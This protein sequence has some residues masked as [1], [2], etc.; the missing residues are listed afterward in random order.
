MTV[1][2]INTGSNGVVAANK[3]VNLALSNPTDAALGVQPISH[4]TIINVNSSVGFLTPAYEINKGTPNGAAVIT[5]VRG[6]GAIGPASV[7]FT[8]TANGTAVPG[9]DYT[10]IMNYT[11]FFA[12]GQ[13]NAT[14]SVPVINNGLVE[15]STTVGMMLFNP[16]NLVL[17]PQNASATLSIVDNGLAT[18]NF[19]F[20]ATNYTVL[21]TGTNAVITVVRTN[22]SVGRISINYA[23]TGGTATP[24]VDYAPTN[25]SLTFSDGSGTSQTF[26]V[27]IFDDL[28][29]TSNV[30]VNLT[31]SNPSGTAQIVGPTTVPLTI[32]NQNVD[33]SFAQFGYFVDE[34]NGSVTIGVT[35]TGNTNVAVSVQ[36]ATTNGTATAGTNYSTTSGALNFGVGETFQTFTIPILYDPQITGNLVFFVNLFNPSS[37]GQLISPVSTTVTVID[38]DSGV[39][40]ASATNSVLKANTNVVISVLRL[41]NTLGQTTVNFNSLGG[42]AQGGIQFAPTN[43]TLTFIPGQSSNSFTLGI[44]NDNQ[45]DGN[46]TVDLNLVNP[47]GAALL[48]PSTEVLTIIDTESGFSF[49]SSGF[50]VTED[51]IAA[52]ITVQR[53]GVTNGTVSVNYATTTNGTAVAGLQYSSTSGILTFTNGQISQTFTIPIIDNNVTGGSETVGLALSNPS[54]TATLVSPSTATLTIFNNDGSLVIPAGSALISPTSG[55]GAI[56]PGENVTLLLAL[57]NT[58]GSNT[59]NLMATL[60]A[61]NGISSP[62]PSGAQSYGVLVTNGASVSRQFSFTASGTNGSIISAVLQLQDGTRNLGTASFSYTLGVVTNTFTNNAVITINDDAVATPYPSTLTVS[63]ISGVISK[64]TATLSGLGHGSMSDVCVLLVGP[65]GQEEL[66][67]GNVGGRH[68]VTNVTL[69]FDDSGVPFTTNAPVTGVYQPTQLPLQFQPLQT[70]N[71]P[72]STNGSTLLPGPYGLSLSSFIGSPLNG[73]WSLYVLDDVPAFGAPSPT[74]GVWRSTR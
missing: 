3:I 64:L 31:L 33:L 63:G 69:T 24:G 61:T 48:S 30:T 43:G 8:T 62:S 54:A 6:G 28:N 66:L 10:P 1:P 51:G 40:F 56:N 72:A 29:L 39:E 34:T 26:T 55:N 60:L 47:V 41:G 27:P 14:V 73:T 9:V 74:D 37:P 44:V 53:T 67:M 50:T 52:T 45:I 12:D 17:Q 16:T 11:I 18:G 58:G 13:S 59:T 36:Y 70:I 57:R 49:A 65:T 15:G 20:S 7:D 42:T 38:D 22:G 2:I 35:R 71:F 21:E 32:L 25:G 46:Q 5:V 19:M 4:L 68:T 23:T